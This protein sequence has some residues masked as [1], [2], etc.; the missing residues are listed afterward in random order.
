MVH[1]NDREEIIELT[2][3]WKG[4]RFPDGRPKVPDAYL[5]AMQNLTLEELWKPIFVKGYESQFEGDL[6]TLHPEFNPDGSVRTFSRGGSD[7]TGAI[8]A[9]ASASDLYENW[10][11]VS[12]M[13]SCD[14]RIVENPA[15]IESIP[16][17]RRKSAEVLF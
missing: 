15:P 9:R 5:D 12:G 8:V 6:K 10:T 2:P 13:L 4:E 17:L 7:V 11:D 14:P 3:L 16:V 1:F